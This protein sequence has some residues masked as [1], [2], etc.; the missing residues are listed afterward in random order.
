M[1][2]VIRQIFVVKYFSQVLPWFVSRTVCLLV[3]LYK[4]LRTN[5]H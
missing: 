1:D 5:F 3:L 2:S 4:K